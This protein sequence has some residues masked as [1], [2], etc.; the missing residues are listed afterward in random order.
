MMN[1]C[2][3]VTGA[4]GF[5][6]SHLVDSLL[7]EDFQ[8]RCLVRKNSNTDYLKQLNVELVHGELTDF[9][10]LRKGVQGCNYVF[11]C[12]AFVSDWGTIAEIRQ[13]NV[14]GTRNLLEAT[15]EQPFCRFI[16]L[17][18]TDVYGH[19]KKKNISEDQ[20]YP[21]KF[22]NWYTQTKMEAELEV[23]YFHTRYQ[24]PVT[25]IRPATV[26]GPRS[27][28]VI[29]E[30]SGAIR[31]GQMLLINDGK[32]NAGLCYISNLIQ[33]IVLAAESDSAIGE[34]FNVADRSQ[35]SW[36]TFIDDLADQL[37]E[38]KKYYNM[39]YGVANILGLL[40]ENSYRVLRMTTGLKFSAL[41]SRQA[42]QVMGREQ[43]FNTDKIQSLLGY[44]PIVNYQ[45]GL[46]ETV[47]W[48]KRLN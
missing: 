47:K 35:V 31:S 41:L 24:L 19:P 26:Y 15:L 22:C 11:H 12:A 29:G 18:T 25:I 14:T 3:F 42:V 27:I 2:C 33:A 6:A 30:I 43:D 20:P 10:S 40:L 1:K 9:E 36:K 21:T 44:R 39:H 17:S 34:C 13:V 28:N 46:K 37:G 38:Q 4:T 7:Q 8:I 16:Y 32:A 23:M 45:L 5:I 48:I